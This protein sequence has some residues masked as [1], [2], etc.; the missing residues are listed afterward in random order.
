MIR[1]Q[2]YSKI[3]NH[4]CVS[5]FG[6][7][8]EYLVLLKSIKPIL[9]QE[10]SKLK[11]SICCKDDKAQIINQDY[12]ITLSQL[13]ETKNQFAYI[14]ELKYNGTTHPIEDFLA[15]SKIK[16]IPDV[17]KDKTQTSRCVIITEGNY[18]TKPLEKIQIEKLKS[19][20]FSKGMSIEI[21]SNNIIGAGL[22]LGVESVALAEAAY[23]GIETH[24]VPTGVGTRL[25]KR[26]FPNLNLVHI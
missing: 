16:N 4:Y 20:A 2:E 23:Q 22:V 13:R 10:F 21:N 8:D 9:D 15:I 18:P 14:S 25:Y 11:I 7:S 24:L 17:V 3:A 19:I 12:V 6:H 26:I 1:F 5:Y